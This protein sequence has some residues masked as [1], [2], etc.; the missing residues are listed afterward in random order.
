MFSPFKVEL[1]RLPTLTFAMSAEK[2]WSIEA[3]ARLFLGVIVTLC[4]GMFLAGLLETA[5]L[6]LAPDQLQFLQ[7]IILVAFF[8][9]AALIWI[10][11]F[12]P[13][14]NISG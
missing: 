10:A 7:M 11:V 14:S 12:L 13:Q 6:G 8:Q 3:V 5:K 4:S 1:S 2:P 9:G